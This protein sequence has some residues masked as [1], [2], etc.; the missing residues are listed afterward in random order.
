MYLEIDDKTINNYIEEYYGNPKILHIIYICINSNNI[1]ECENNITKEEI[2]I[3]CNDL[4]NKQNEI[5]IKS[6]IKQYIK[7]REII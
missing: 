3:F 6:Q 7:K 2:D 4:I 5:L 1:N